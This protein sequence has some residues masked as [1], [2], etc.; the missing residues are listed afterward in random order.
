M[1][2][3]HDWLS[4]EVRFRENI[5]QAKANECS[6]YKSATTIFSSSLPIF[7]I[8]IFSSDTQVCFALLTSYNTAC[9]ALITLDNMPSNT[10]HNPLY[11]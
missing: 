11:P 3:T 4:D 9:F 6:Q 1:L 5:K 10:L 2:F 8:Y 7:T